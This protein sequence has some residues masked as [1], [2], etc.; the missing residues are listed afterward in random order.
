MAILAWLFVL[1][2]S[3]F[4][5]KNITN[6][7]F[8]RK[9]LDVDSKIR[10]IIMSSR[11]WRLFQISIAMGIIGGH[12]DFISDHKLWYITYVIFSDYIFK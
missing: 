1:I 6:D 10:L 2:S 12:I 11:F 5:N 8:D 4:V 7:L 9:N 3:H